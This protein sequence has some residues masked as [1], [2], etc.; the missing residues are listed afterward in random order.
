MNILELQDKDK[1]N[2]K[3]NTISLQYSTTSDFERYSSP[4]KRRDKVPPLNLVVLLD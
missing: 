2:L 1:I 4:G 3:G